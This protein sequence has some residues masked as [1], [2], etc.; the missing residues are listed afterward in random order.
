MLATKREKHFRFEL[1]EYG[2]GFE[3]T[4]SGF[5]VRCLDHSSQPYNYGGNR[6]IRTHTERILSPLPAACWA[7]FPIWWKKPD[8]N[9]YYA[10]FE[11]ADSANWSILP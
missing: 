10:A 6:G 5:A 1:M 11:E 3:P 4:Q 8:S 2:A 9:R 7:R